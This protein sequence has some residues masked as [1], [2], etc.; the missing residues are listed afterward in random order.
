MDPEKLESAGWLGGLAL[1]ILASV[2]GLSY[3]RRDKNKEMDFELESKKL[4]LQRDAQENLQ[5]E[6]ALPVWESLFNKV[7]DKVD[8]LE[9]SLFEAQESISNLKIELVKADNR[10]KALEK[11]LEHA[12]FKQAQ[13]DRLI[14]EKTAR[15]RELK[16]Q[17]SVMKNKI[18]LLEAS[19]RGPEYS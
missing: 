19:A 12:R 10:I 9:K 2:K 15:I 4:D 5:E 6:R 7:S 14:A 13:D 18:V 17:L 1:S 3:F 11:E 8:S 16:H